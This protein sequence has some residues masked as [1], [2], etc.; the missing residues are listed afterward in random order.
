MKNKIFLGENDLRHWSK[1]ENDKKSHFYSS[2]SL[3]L[4]TTSIFLFLILIAVL[5][6]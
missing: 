2:V 6:T 5:T 4:G 1:L 3:V